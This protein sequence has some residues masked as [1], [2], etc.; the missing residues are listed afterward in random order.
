MYL[1][2][3]IIQTSC[4]F[5]TVKCYIYIIPKFCEQSLMERITCKM[6]KKCDESKFKVTCQIIILR[7]QYFFIIMYSKSQHCLPLFL[8]AVSDVNFTNEK[9]LQ[10]ITTNLL[11]ST[12]YKIKKTSSF[13]ITQ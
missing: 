6:L 9:H 13:T 11:R 1:F 4:S 5:F 2:T 7:Y 8:K 3:Y 12:N 10:S